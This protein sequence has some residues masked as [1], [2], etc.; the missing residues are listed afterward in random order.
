MGHC[1]VQFSSTGNGSPQHLCGFSFVTLWCSVQADGSGLLRTH[2]GFSLG[3]L[4]GSVQ[5][6]GIWSPQGLLQVQFLDIVA[7]SSG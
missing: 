4:Q 3:T 1:G 6:D 2:W 7:F 5:A